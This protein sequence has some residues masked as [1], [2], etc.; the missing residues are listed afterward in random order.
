MT[1]ASAQAVIDR[2]EVDENFA[3]RVKDVGDPEASLAV[4]TSEGFNVTPSDMRDA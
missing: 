2:M 3:N 1:L 4:I